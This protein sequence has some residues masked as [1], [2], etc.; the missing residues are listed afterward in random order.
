MGFITVSNGKGQGYRT[1]D[2]TTP[3]RKY[4]DLGCSHWK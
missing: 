1:N 3:Q 4:Q 2:K